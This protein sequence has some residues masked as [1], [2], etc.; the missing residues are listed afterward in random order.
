[1]LQ[2]FKFKQD[3]NFNYGVVSQVMATLEG[4]IWKQQ[5]T[6]FQQERQFN[7]VQLNDSAL[8]KTNTELY[9][10]AV[11]QIY[12][13][14]KSVRDLEKNYGKYQYPDNYSKERLRS[15][16]AKNHES[17]ESE[18][19]KHLLDTFAIAIRLDVPSLKGKSVDDMAQINKK[20]MD[21]FTQENPNMEKFSINNLSQL[22]Q[23]QQNTF[24]QMKEF[25]T[26]PEKNPILMDNSTISNN[27]KHTE[28]E[29]KSKQPSHCKNPQ[30]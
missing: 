12:I 29:P 17:T 21:N 10:Q 30:N 19:L 3:Y 16:I 4:T 18:E 9:A 8:N 11:A 20:I 5:K 25:E 23:L 7:K 27:K 2:T 28:I 6:H 13:L 22:A 15:F 14:E 26:N 24:D 1:M